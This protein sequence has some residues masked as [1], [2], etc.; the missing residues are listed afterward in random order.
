MNKGYLSPNEFE[1][2]LPV[3]DWE[4]LRLEIESFYHTNKPLFDQI[5]HGKDISI[6]EAAQEVF[7]RLISDYAQYKNK[8]PDVDDQLLTEM[9]ADLYLLAEEYGYEASPGGD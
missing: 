9:F 3:L 4:C 6:K 7:Y 5:T 1:T 2:D 8:P